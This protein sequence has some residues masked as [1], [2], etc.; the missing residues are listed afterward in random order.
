MSRNEKLREVASKLPPVPKLTNN[1]K[2]MRDT[3]GKPVMRD[4]F[5]EM[6][7]LK[8]EIEEKN[9]HLDRHIVRNMQIRAIGKYSE[10]MQEIARQL[11]ARK[12]IKY[13]KWGIAILFWIGIGIYLAVRYL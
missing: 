1:R 12:R 13:Y 6:V 5:R 8:N 2:I 3:E 9:S 11:G 10:N 4:H 7:S